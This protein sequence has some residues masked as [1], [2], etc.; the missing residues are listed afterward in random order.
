MTR[1]VYMTLREMKVK[2]IE[3]L[4]LIGNFIYLE[5]MVLGEHL[6]CVRLSARPFT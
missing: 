1:K 6:L 2:L 4:L 5:K 3:H